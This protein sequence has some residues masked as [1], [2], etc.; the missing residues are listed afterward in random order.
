[1]FTSFRSTG[2]TLAL[3]LGIASTQVEAAPCA[4]FVDVDDASP[5][6]PAVSY[7]RSRGITAGCA[8]DL[9][10]PNDAVTRRTIA[11]F[12]MRLGQKMGMKTL[13]DAN[14]NA[15]GI[16]DL[17]KEPEVAYHGPNG[18]AHLGVLLD[19]YGRPAGLTGSSPLFFNSGD[20]SG[21]AYRVA[22]DSNP[23][24]TWHPVDNLSWPT[25]TANVRGSVRVFYGPVQSAP[26]SLPISYVNNV[27]QLSMLG[28][29]GVCSVVDVSSSWRFQPVSEGEDLGALFSGPFRWE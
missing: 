14:G 15:V 29:N 16:A 27:G 18:L 7:L 28:T 24:T 19:T 23:G 10:C 25:I 5:Y 11:V 12:L 17:R 3:V 21:Q 2:F 6:C 26:V 9:Y 1:M 4:G 20:C 22:G 8:A 13:I